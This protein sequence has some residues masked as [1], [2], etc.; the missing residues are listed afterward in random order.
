MRASKSILTA[1][2][3]GL[4]ALVAA[5]AALTRADEAKQPLPT[6][7]GDVSRASAVEVRDASG[8]VVL[9]GTFGEAAPA[10]SDGDVERKA[11]LAARD[12]SSASGEAEVE[13]TRS[14]SG[15]VEQEVELDAEKLAPSAAYTL[16]LDGRQVA[17]FTTDAKGGAEVE[18][19]SSPRK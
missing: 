14:S 16:H 4:A 18:L 10:S 9:Q 12:G 8:R 1:A 19:T 6:D 11:T 3:F 13:V 7:A 2:L 17:S 15:A 5:G